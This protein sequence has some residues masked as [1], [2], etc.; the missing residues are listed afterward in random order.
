MQGKTENNNS[1]SNER[2]HNNNERSQKNEQTQGYEEIPK[3][4]N[5]VFLHFKE[6]LFDEAIQLLE[7]VLKIDF[8]YKGVTSALK[9][10]TF[11]SEKKKKLVNVNDKF[12]RAEFLLGQW[13]FFTQFLTHIGETS[14][15]CLYSIKQFAFG[16]ALKLYLEIFDDSGF[17]DADVLLKLGRCYKALGNFDKAI[18]YLGIAHQQR[19]G[20]AVILAELADCYSLIN[21]MRISKALFREAFF[22]EPK[23]I[24]LLAIDSGMIQNLIKKCLEKGLRKEE[25]STWIPVYGTIYGVFSI[26]R[27]LRP[28]EFGKLRQSIYALE[29]EL[30][31]ESEDKHIKKPILINHYF[32]LI[33][34]Y[35]ST[36]EDTAKI[37]EVLQKLKHIDSTIY[38]EYIQ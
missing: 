17:Y 21:E 28:L 18:E 8:E 38:H 30:A 15:R 13:D 20:S 12:E 23:A 25:L 24:N 19:T 29:K 26:K 2:T 34:H 36:G 16:K 3:I 4:L 14:E 9:C 6:G 27:E 10:A 31:G 7:E 33:D 1:H 22:I 37:E 5:N 35:V 32:W 11:W